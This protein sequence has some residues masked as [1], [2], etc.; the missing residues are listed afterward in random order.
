MPT[1][2]AS[3]VPNAAYLNEAASR[4]GVSQALLQGMLD[5]DGLTMFSLPAPAVAFADQLALKEDG[6]AQTLLGSEQAR[7]NIIAA[8]WFL[9]EV[10]VMYGS[11]SE[12]VSQFYGGGPQG[13][14]K[15]TKIV[16]GPF[17]KRRRQWA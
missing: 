15:A 13:R 11:Q 4:Y 9:S 16:A 3:G 8:A 6:T 17:E 1:I 10:H 7:W 14:V 2:Y 5:I 12:A